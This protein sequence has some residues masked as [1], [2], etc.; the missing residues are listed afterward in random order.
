[1]RRGRNLWLLV[2]AL[3][4][5]AP[6]HAHLT[7]TGFGPFYDGLAHPFVTPE[8]LLPVLALTLLAGLRGARPGRWVLFALPAAWGVGMAAGRL[9]SPPASAVWLTC[10]LTIALGALTAAD[11]KLPLS[12]IA[13]LA[14]TLGLVHGCLNGAGLAHARGAAQGMA[15]IAC[16]IFVIV[17][18]A[19]GPVVS[20]RAAWARV[21]V[22]VAGSWI[23]AM[24]FLMLGWTVRNA[25][26]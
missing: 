13:G 10:G 21:A 9:A 14:A 11:R 25:R 6:A 2:P 12:A 7:S 19:A 24:G 22:R 8:D 15:G 4:W 17:A 16:A 23:A 20:L 3:L 5:P 1:M 18:L 26:L